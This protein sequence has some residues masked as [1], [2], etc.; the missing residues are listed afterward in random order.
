MLRS[1]IP[2]TCIT[3]VNFFHPKTLNE[4]PESIRQA[5]P[6]DWSS[7]NLALLSISTNF[8]HLN[9]FDNE[10][11]ETIF[12]KAGEMMQEYAKG[13]IT[14]TDNNTSHDFHFVVRAKFTSDWKML[15]ALRGAVARD[16]ASDPYFAWVRNSPDKHLLSMGNILAAVDRPAFSTAGLVLAPS[17]FWLTR[18]EYH[19]HLV[20]AYTIE[21]AFS[22]ANS[23]AWRDSVLS[24]TFTAIPGTSG[25]K[26]NPNDND[27]PKM[28]CLTVVVQL[29]NVDMPNKGDS[30]EVT[31]L[32]FP[33]QECPV[34]EHPIVA[35]VI[36]DSDNESIDG[37][38]CILGRPQQLLIEDRE[39]KRQEYLAERAKIW[40]GYIMEVRDGVVTIVITRP[41]DPRWKGAKEIQPR[42]NTIIPVHAQ[43]FRY[44]LR[45]QEE[46]KVAQKHRII[47]DPLLSS[48][49]YKDRE[50]YSNNL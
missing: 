13:I 40:R 10:I 50:F 2:S 35:D 6:A 47:I 11:P 9:A 30:V 31:L 26:D 12:P 18:L 43:N 41:S 38:E 23:A 32:D 34:A 45:Y 42:V 3:D 21:H 33:L 28:Y 27:L 7:E 29:A 14:N 24:A 36:V 5:F 37:K 49:T 1:T 16:K 20:Y 15:V 25:L 4:L 22:V 48:R 19:V 46:L 8:V 39:E 17:S 44:S